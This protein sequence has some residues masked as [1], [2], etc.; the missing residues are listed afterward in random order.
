MTTLYDYNFQFRELE[1]Q[2]KCIVCEKKIPQKTKV[3][4]IKVD[5]KTSKNVSICTKCLKIMK[6]FTEGIVE[7]NLEEYEDD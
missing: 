4:R 7:E 5:N 6:D 3:I 2:G 1:R